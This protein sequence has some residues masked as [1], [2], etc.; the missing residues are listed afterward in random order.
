FYDLDHPL[1]FA[2]IR[3]YYQSFGGRTR[4]TFDP[5]FEVLK[6]KFTLGAE[7]NEGLTKGLQYVNNKGREGTIM[8]NID[9]QNTQYS[10]FYQSETQLAPH[11]TLTLG[12]SYNSLDYN[13][14][15]YLK[16]NQSGVKK[17]D[18]QASPRIALTHT[19]SPAFSLHGSIS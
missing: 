10:L 3:N 8:T 16:Q 14:K 13:V 12:L 15:D 7:F 19:F 17:F 2:Y 4:F 5:D 18:P 11:T 9:Y 1:A 6:T